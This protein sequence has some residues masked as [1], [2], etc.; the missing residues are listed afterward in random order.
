MK[1]MPQPKQVL[2]QINNRISRLVELGLADHQQLAFLRGT[3]RRVAVVFPNAE[4]MSVALRNIDY[5]EMYR[6]LVRER[7]YNI[8]MCD[9][10][11]IQMMY[12]YS[13]QALLRHRLAFLPAPHL[14]EFQNA[15]ETYI[16]DELHGDVV[17]RNVLPVP[18]RYDYDAREGRHRAVEHPLSHLTLG[19][20]E[21]CRVPVSAPVTPSWFIDF[22]VRNFYHTDARCYADEMPPG[23]AV[24]GE[25]ILPEE[26]R[27]VHVQIPVQTSAS[28]GR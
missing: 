7:A 14:D 11:L 1:L 4:H 27:V 9:G 8:K 19:Q 15:P 16:E 10:A 13:N 22:V 18:L 5:R 28:A 26:R 6:L 17:T 24:F 2:R 25:S 3:G 23:G 21:R 12:D 20:Y